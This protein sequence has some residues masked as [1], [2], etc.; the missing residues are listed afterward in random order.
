LIDSTVVCTEMADINRSEYIII[1]RAS[2]SKL[3]KQAFK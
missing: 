1:R 2:C 3:A